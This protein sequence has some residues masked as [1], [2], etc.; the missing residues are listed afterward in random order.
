[1]HS[2]LIARR[3]VAAYLHGYSG[4]FILSAV[5]FITGMLFQ[6]R[7]LGAGAQYSHEVLEAFFENCGGLVMIASIL[8]TMRSLAEERQ[9]GTEVL[10]RTSPATETQ[11]V[12][13]KYLAAMAVLSGLL[14]LTTYMPALIFVNGKVS[15][16]HIA[17]GYLGLLCLASSTSAVG[18]AASS[19]F[20][21]QLPAGILAAVIVVTMLLGWMLSDLVNAPFA[22]VLAYAAYWDKHF[23]AFMEGRLHLRSVVY[24]LSVTFAFLL[25]ATKVLEG[26]RWR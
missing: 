23:T 7:G 11:I 14:L 24:Y 10:L 9:T 15:V 18:I 5:L 19:L 16:G 4:Y 6:V 21:A 12:F 22:D 1:M 17:V 20:K 3:D 25:V 2:L 13:G 8:L 26:R